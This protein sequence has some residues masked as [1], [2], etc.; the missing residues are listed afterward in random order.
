MLLHLVSINVVSIL[1]KLCRVV[2]NM[3]AAGQLANF[4]NLRFFFP[5][6]SKL[7][8]QDTFILSMTTLLLLDIFCIIQGLRDANVTACP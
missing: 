3:K 4:T 1:T 2:V 7:G 5:F 6:L 8:S